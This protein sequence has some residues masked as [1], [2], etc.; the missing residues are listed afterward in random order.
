MT[1]GIPIKAAKDLAKQYD[2]KQVIILAWDGERE[3]CVTFGKTLEDCDQAAE[4]GNCIKRILGW[5]ESLCSSVPSR[6]VRLKR[7][8]EE[9]E[10]QLMNVTYIVQE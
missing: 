8:I 4:S 7:R 10:K 9:L 1:K 5:P 3:H 6:I 2:L